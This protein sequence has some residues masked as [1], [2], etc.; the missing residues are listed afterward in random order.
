MPRYFFHLSFGNRIC[1]DEEGFEFPCRAA[2]RAEAFAVIRDL[3]HGRGEENARGWGGWVL[4]VADAEGEFL[5]L[6]IAEPL[7]TVASQPPRSK[8]TLVSLQGQLAELAQR[9]LEI[10]QRTIF[11]LQV[12]RQLRQELGSE[13]DRGARLKSVADGLLSGTRS[14]RLAAAD[15]NDLRLATRPRRRGRPQLVVLQGVAG[16]EQSVMKPRRR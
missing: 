12:D 8:T 3:G 2:A 6:P 1:R 9:T 16:D 4:C 14:L 5:S 15:I 10:R 7:L 11:L 13:F